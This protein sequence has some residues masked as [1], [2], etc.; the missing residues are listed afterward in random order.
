MW[1]GRRIS[2]S[3]DTE[4]V[5][6]VALTTTPEKVRDWPAAIEWLRRWTFGAMLDQAGR[7]INWVIVIRPGVLSKWVDKISAVV[8]ADG[9]KA[10]V[11]SSVD[12]AS[13]NDT[14]S[15][16]IEDLVTRLPPDVLPRLAGIATVN[17]P[18][19]MSPYAFIARRIAGAVMGKGW[20]KAQRRRQWML[21]AGG[22]ITYR[23]N[24]GEVYARAAGNLGATMIEPVS[25]VAHPETIFEYLNDRR[26]W[27]PHGKQGIYGIP[28]G[29][30]P[31]AMW[32]VP[33]GNPDS[34]MRIKVVDWQGIKDRFQLPDR[35]DAEKV[36]T[37]GT[38][39]SVDPE[40][41]P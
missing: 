4:F 14:A 37:E 32:P 25:Y 30:D 6:P 41:V 38:A 3:S 18:W 21:R 27:W 35:A 1:G 28:G 8:K 26:D 2:H 10:A 24:E 23:V 9:I 15:D 22:A 17:I 20:M 40:R 13:E 7:D 33:S 34:R 36:T 29:E 31:M 5:L 39:E 16:Y 19:G 12:N 11:T